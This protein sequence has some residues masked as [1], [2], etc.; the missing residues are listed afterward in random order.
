MYYVPWVLWSVNKLLEFKGIK[1]SYGVKLL[2]AFAKYGTYDITSVYCSALGVSNRNAA[3]SIANAYKKINRKT[4]FGALLNWMFALSLEDIQKILN[5]DRLS[6]CTYVDVKKGR[7]YI[8][9]IM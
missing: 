3:K 9:Q 7:E 8:S 5:N 2:P 1:A 4:E 6:D